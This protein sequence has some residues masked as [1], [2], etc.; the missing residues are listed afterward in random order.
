MKLYIS[1]DYDK[2]VDYLSEFDIVTD[3][4]KSNYVL[5]L[6]GGLG[7]LYDLF[8]SINDKKRIILYNDNFFYTPIIKRLY[9]MYEEGIVDRIPSEYMYI[10]SDFSEI[11]KKL[12]DK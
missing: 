2:Y 4:D 8:K 11:I 12:E 5:I 6:P 9:E 1:G 7:C 3:I 10:E